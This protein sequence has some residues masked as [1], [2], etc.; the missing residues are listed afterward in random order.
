MFY[1]SW[2]STLRT[3]AIALFGILLFVAFLVT[4]LCIGMTL[5]GWQLVLVSSSM[6]IFLVV[7]SFAWRWIVDRKRQSLLNMDDDE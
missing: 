4:V 7:M 5:N 1:S 2:T 3:V 6:L